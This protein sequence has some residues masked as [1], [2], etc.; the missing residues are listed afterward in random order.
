M[1]APRQIRCRDRAAQWQSDMHRAALSIMAACPDDADAIGE[2]LEGEIAKGPDFSRQHRGSAF[3]DA[4]KVNTDRNFCARLM[5]IADVI[6]RKTWRSRSKGK[7]GGT[8]GR[9]ALSLLRVLMFV[10]K[11]SA[12][13]L[14][15]S[16]DH[17]ARL[18]RMSR[19]TVVTAM[20]I[21]VRMGVVTAHRRI[22]RVRTPLGV[23]VVQDSNAYEYHM[24]KGLGA[25]AWS[26]FRPPSECNNSS[27]RTVSEQTLEDVDS[28]DA[29]KRLGKGEKWQRRT[30]T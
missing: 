9:S 18:C 27:A 19:R 28:G 26:I 1:S 5:F 15:P 21:L 13:K 11:K 6:E 7:H 23:R 16:Y 2:H 4:P 17:L 8:L 22:K 20:G 10:V 24:P 12:G 3:L 25:L 14:F 30:Q 29:V